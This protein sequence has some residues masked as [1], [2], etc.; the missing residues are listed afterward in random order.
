MKRLHFTVTNGLNHDQRMIR[1][2]SSLAA[3][4]YQV[5]LV[6]VENKETLQPKPY[7]QKRLSTGFKKGPG[8]Y[9]V[10]QLR[11]FFYLLFIKTDLLCCIDLDTMLP[12]WL[13]AKLRGKKMLYDA[14]EYFSQQK[15][16]IT[17]P[18]VYR[19]WHWI[20]RTFVPKFKHG[21]TVSESIARAFKE[22][23]GV[24][25]AVIRN[26]PLLKT[27]PAPAP[28]PEKFILYQGAVN[29]ARGLEFL[30]PAMKQVPV[31]LHIYGD[32]NFMETVKEM[33][34]V[35]NLGDKVLLKGKV[36]PGELD[37]ITQSAYIGIN[38]VENTGLNQYYSLAN[39]FFDY[40]Q[41]GI[42]Q[43]SMNFPEYKKINDEWEVAILLDELTE[44]S[45][46]GALNGL[47]NDE[48]RYTKLQQQC[49]AAR[50]ILNWQ[51]EEKK[52]LAFYKAIV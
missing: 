35:N 30:I 3:A 14:H 34:R 46:A 7:A 52:L 21:Y 6:G 17:R 1:I 22:K 18:K 4:G 39:K 8:F 50:E 26:M 5:K 44:E 2:C 36:L 49:L 41:N 48:Y 25:Y 11:L 10:Y 37:R 45:I 33:I 15:E 32:G 38:L 27:L 19:V 47:L 28:P 12:V 40:L 13:V 51:E 29:E 23:Y 16:I 43:L 42:P 31:Q 20:E 9:A 24:D